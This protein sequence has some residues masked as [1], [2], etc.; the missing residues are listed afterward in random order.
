MRNTGSENAVQNVGHKGR[1]HR[2]KMEASRPERH[3]AIRDA[4]RRV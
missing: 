3:Q 4:K 1:V 2:D